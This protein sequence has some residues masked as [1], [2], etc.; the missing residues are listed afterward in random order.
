MGGNHQSVGGGGGG[1]GGQLKLVFASGESPGLA[2]QA[3]PAGPS[4]EAQQ[5][6]N[7]KIRI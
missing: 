5:E 6:S 3:D 7:E 4:G 1:G 2:L